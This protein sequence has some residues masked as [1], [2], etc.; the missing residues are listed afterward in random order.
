MRQINLTNY[1]VRLRDETGEYKDEPYEVKDA[2]VEILF[3]RCLGLSGAEILKRDDL[4]HKI[5]DC[6]DGKVLLEEEEW[7][8]FVT[9]V[10]TVKGLGR[11]DVELVRR[12]IEA[13]KIEVE[14]KKK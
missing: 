3:A 4:A 10:N 5:M 1:S 8:K 2:L 13:P 9:A 14:E 12:I 11:T 7:N 6:A